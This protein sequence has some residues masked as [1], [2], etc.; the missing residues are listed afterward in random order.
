MLRWGRI[1]QW[2]TISGL[3]KYISITAYPNLCTRSFNLTFECREH[4]VYAPATEQSRQT[5]L[6]VSSLHSFMVFMW[7]TCLIPIDS[8]EVHWCLVMSWATWG[9]LFLHACTCAYLESAFKSFFTLFVLVLDTTTCHCLHIY[10]APLIQ[11]S[12]AVWALIQEN[13][14]YSSEIFIILFLCR[15]KIWHTQAKQAVQCA[16]LGAPMPWLSAL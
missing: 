3:Q 10:V 4:I 16:Q 5:H 12:Q 14:W 6:T 7:I 9:F 2:I 13:V 1:D 15:R 8:L 11:R